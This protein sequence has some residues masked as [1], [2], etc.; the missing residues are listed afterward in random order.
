MGSDIGW[1]DAGAEAEFERMDRKAIY[2]EGGRDILVIKA[3]GAYY[4]ISNLC[5]HARAHLGEG[6]REGHT[7]A[8]PWHGALFDIRTGRHLS[9]PAVRPVDA[10]E[11]RV[12]DGRV[13]V[14][15]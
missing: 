2:V 15:V 10:Y 3:D 6:D 12:R 8:C 5:S 1:V 11:T 13:W 14:K 9:P 4:A 7:I